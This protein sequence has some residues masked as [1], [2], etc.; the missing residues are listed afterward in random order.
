[1]GKVYLVGAG[2]GD[3]ELITVKGKR[4]IENCDCV[5]YDR[6]AGDELLALM[7]ADSAKIYVG[8]QPGKHYR[9]QE[10]INEILVEA[11]KSF[12]TV[13]RLKG[14]DP[15]V[16][17]RGGEE[18]EALNEAGIS[19]EVV[20][21]ITSA[22]AVPECA[23]IPVTHRGIA[24]SFHIITG[25]TFDPAKND[26]DNDLK[27]IDFKNLAVQGGTLVFLM[28]LA[29]IRRITD[30]LIAY[31]KS[32]DT[33]AAVI[34]DGTTIYERTVRGVL[35]DIADKALEEGLTSPA[36]I[37]IGES[38][39]KQYRCESEY[40]SG[41]GLVR[42]GVV[43]TPSLYQ[44]LT[45]AFI[46]KGISTALICDM[47]VVPDKEGMNRLSEIISGSACGL[48]GYTWILFTSQ[49][50]VRLFFELFLQK[51]EDYRKLSS[52]KFGVI[53]EGT[54][55]VLLQYG[56]AADYI[57][58]KYTV[59]SF[60]EEFKTIVKMWDK[61][62]VPRA[63]QGSEELL[64]YRDIWKCTTEVISIYDVKGKATRHI[65]RLDEYTHL[66]FA[67]ASGV[68][69]FISELETNAL[70]IPENV[71]TLCIGE[72][73]AKKLK[74]YGFEAD[75]TASASDVDG[76]LDTLLES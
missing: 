48:Q 44:R 64:K 6:L 20:P 27:G 13:V 60:C 19:Y 22:I 69:A 10:E 28:G 46:K 61:V 42:V 32:P 67:S 41:E 7:P 23:G 52:V 54:R 21:G 18:I 24:R 1:M 45:G 25:H 55:Q 62:L 26:T 58:T 47:A 76:L 49:N 15:F 3:P 31:G 16:F 72:I 8:K 65:K 56:F 5:I 43:A 11:A 35:S 51:G 39:A 66:V 70:T 38:A 75:L 17:G 12:K 33:P 9:K 14:G 2:P 40:K 71:K 68:S 53:G 50:A 59:H 37:V 73:T 29:N 74:E 34:S 57:P 30:E 36:I 4:I 63:E